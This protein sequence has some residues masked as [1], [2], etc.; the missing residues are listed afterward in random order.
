LGLMTHMLRQ[1]NAVQ[2]DGVDFYEQQNCLGVQ[3]WRDSRSYERVQP[4][5]RRAE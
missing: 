2:A 1:N 4:S 3:Q 5:K